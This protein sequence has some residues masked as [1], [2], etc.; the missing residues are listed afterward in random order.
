MNEKDEWGRVCEMLRLL[1]FI[2]TTS[3][4]TFA[5][6]PMRMERDVRRMQQ[7]SEYVMAHYACR[8][9]L[10]DIATEVGMNRSAFGSNGIKESLFQNILPNIDC[11]RHVS[12]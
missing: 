10:N 4:H 7:I 8:I 11:T 1:P 12:C 9:T 5:G 6:N 3:D 2:F